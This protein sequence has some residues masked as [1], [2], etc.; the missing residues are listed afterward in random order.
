MNARQHQHF[1]IHG[2]AKDDAEHD[3]WIARIDGLWCE[4]EQFC[5]VAPLEDPNEHA[6]RCRNGQDVHGDGFDGDDDRPNLQEDEEGRG[7]QNKRQRSG[8]VAGDGVEVVGVVGCKPCD[9][10]SVVIATEFI[11]KL[12]PFVSDFFHHHSRI[13]VGLGAFELHRHHRSVVADERFSKAFS[14]SVL[15]GVQEFARCAPK[16]HDIVGTHACR[17]QTYTDA[18]VHPRVVQQVGEVGVLNP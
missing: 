11:E 13:D 14:R 8:K 5:S 18:S 1:V 3:D 6:K 7:D 10:K 16:L 17:G 12:V 15:R 9:Q 4:V 2:Q